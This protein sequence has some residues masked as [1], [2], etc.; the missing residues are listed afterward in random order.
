ML[1]RLL[2][3]NLL[4]ME[5]AELTLGPGLNVLTGET[6]AG[7]SLLASALDL[8]L[9]GR[10]RAGLVR[11]GAAEAYVEGIFTLPPWLAGDERLP[12]DAQE[13]VL[14][15]RVWP[16]GRTRA[17]LCG[18]AATLADLR[19][20]GARLLAFYGQHEHRK[21]TVT[22]AQLDVLDR[23]CGPAQGQRRAEVTI[24]HETVRRIEARLGGLGT[25]AGA[26]ER[27]L[28]LIAFELAEIDAV[29]PSVTE[30]ADLRGERE[31]L[32]HAEGLRA[33]AAAAADGLSPRE[34]GTG[35]VGLLARAAEEIAAAA[36]FDGQLGAVAERLSSLRYEA[37]DVAGELRAYF[38]AVEAEPGRLEAVED[39]LEALARLMRKHGGSVEAVLA[40]AERCRAREAELRGLDVNLAA[41][42]GELAQARAHRAAL[43]DELTEARRAAAPE[44]AAAV[45]ERLGELAMAEAR[46]EVTVTPRPDG[47]A[48]SGQ[49]VV[50]FLIAPN[51]GLAIGPLREV[52]SGGEMSRVM[53]ALLSVAHA[54]GHRVSPGGSEGD[55]PA[56]RG[57]ALLVFDE[58]DAG[59]GGHTARAVGSHLRALAVGRQVL[60]ITHLPQVAALAH[61][62][63]SIVKDNRR[64]PSVTTVSRLDGDR[65]LAELVRMLGA[66]AEDTAAR[67]HA[68]ELLKAA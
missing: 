15:R 11:D 60:C 61:R 49:D 43:A 14:A 41:L 24:A 5:R 22:A 17:Y 3:E 6:G 32:R 33:A 35:A 47:P 10:T 45:V 26:R 34:E 28:D 20:L 23:Y 36:A 66:D 12:A 18:R 29:A 48:A 58:I 54:P 2:I 31:R 13:L 64:S 40:H 7:K 44:L 53:L 38:E 4:L 30:E 42:E 62:H 27:E 65:I 8:L 21:L 46:F 51:P 9:G 59:I 57:E 56:A 67:G 52:A 55:D 63:F 39:R 1:E 19:E 68:R 50:E 16:D 37:E 25:D